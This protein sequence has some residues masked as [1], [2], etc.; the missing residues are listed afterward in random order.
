MADETTELIHAEVIQPL[1]LYGNTEGMDSI[2]SAIRAAATAIPVDLTT[3]KGRKSIASTAH[4]VSRLKTTFDGMGKAMVAEWKGKAKAVDA[5]RKRLRDDLDA[6][7]I[8]V[9]QPLTDFEDA[10]KARVAVRRES[11]RDIES[12]YGILGPF[13]VPSSPD[14]MREVLAKIEGERFS[15]ERF[16]ELLAE[17]LFAKEKTTLA[18]RTAIET[19]ETQERQRLELEKLKVEQAAREQAE[20][21]ERIRR[22]AVEAEHKEAALKAAEAK[23]IA[24]LEAAAARDRIEIA[25]EKRKRAELEAQTAA[26]RERQKIEEEAQAARAEEER[27][28]KDEA[29]REAAIDRVV[30]HLT[31]GIHALSPGRAIW[32]ASDIADGKVPGVTMTV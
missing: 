23:A 16:G 17:S 10:E 12:G 8:E 9:R 26:L 21:E 19:A 1:D 30:K 7:K 6:L 3:A 32:I 31:N 5:E 11:I 13:A 14:K 25:E 22:E 18:L 4:K 15:K 27:R 20:R 24:D 28:A 29:L 2:L